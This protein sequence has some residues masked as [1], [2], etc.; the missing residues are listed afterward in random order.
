[1]SKHNYFANFGPAISLVWYMLK[2]SFISVKEKH[3]VDF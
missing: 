3:E 1:M 2:Q